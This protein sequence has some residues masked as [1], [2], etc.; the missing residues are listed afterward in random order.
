MKLLSSNSVHTCRIRPMIIPVLVLQASQRRVEQ[1]VLHYHYT[2]WPDMG[3]PEYT[4]P[5]LSFIR[6]SS[7]ART[8]EMGPV[9]VHCR[10]IVCVCLC[11]CVTVSNMLKLRTSVKHAMCVTVPVLEGQEP[12]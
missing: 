1:T 10:Y 12:T 2:Q 8:Q 3:V 4:L 6:A 7:W 5:V 9:L 11:V